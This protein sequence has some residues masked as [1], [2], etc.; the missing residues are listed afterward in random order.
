MSPSELFEGCYIPIVSWPLACQSQWHSAFSEPGLFDKDKPACHWRPATIKKTADGFG[1]FISFTI[2]AGVFDRDGDVATLVTRAYIIGFIK[3]MKASNYAPYTI[4]CH[5]QEVY[6]AARVMDPTQ[7]W[8]WLKTAVKKL[9]SRS[10]PVRNK[11]S[12]IQPADALERLGRSLI[13]KAENGTNLSFYK[14]A[15]MFRD[16]LMISVLIRRPFRLKNFAS[17]TL[18]ANLIIHEA[19]ASFLFSAD[20]MKGKRPFEVMHPQEYFEGLQIY[21]KHY[22]PYLLDLTQENDESTRK[23][24]K[25]GQNKALWISNEGRALAEESLRNAIRKRTKAAFGIDMTPHLFRDSSV[26]TLI[27]HAPES[28][29][30]TRSILGHTTIDMT[31]AHYNQARMVETSRR[32]TNLIETL[33][34]N[35]TQEAS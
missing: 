22:R 18:E 7:D 33:T 3:A 6:D 10:R 13:N 35:L 29:R 34:N 32:H 20:E 19:S 25:S 8:S 4:F 17:L 30:I 23:L 9:R 28:A 11:L 2:F 31:N 14:R 15:L 12:R 1:N 21:L 24:N 5:V 26:T 16:G 27:R